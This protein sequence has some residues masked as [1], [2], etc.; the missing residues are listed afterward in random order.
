MLSRRNVLR[1]ASATGAGLTLGSVLR[2]NN[3]LAAQA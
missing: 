3:A 2:P 1:A